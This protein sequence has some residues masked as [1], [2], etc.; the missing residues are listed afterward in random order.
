MTVSIPAAVRKNAVPAIVD[1]TTA[2]N[3]YFKRHP[4]YARAVEIFMLAQ[5]SYSAY[6]KM[7]DRGRP[8]RRR[9]ARP[10]PARRRIIRSVPA[11]SS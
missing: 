4:R 5:A 7:R 6:S 3:P 8:P 2:L 1:A 9:A 11:S 10:R